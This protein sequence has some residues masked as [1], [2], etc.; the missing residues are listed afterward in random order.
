MID[1]ELSEDHKALV[2]TVREFAQNEVAPHIKEWDEK[3]QFN[4][5]VLKQMASLNLLGVCIPEEYGGFG[6]SAKVYNRIFGEL[7]SIDPALTVYFGAHQ[8]IGCKGIILFGNEEQKHRF[9]PKCAS[10]ESIAAFCLTE[11]GSGSDAQA[12]RSTAVPSADGSHYVLNG[13]KIWI[14]NAGYADVLTVFAKVPVEVDG[15]KKA[16]VTAFVVDA[17]AAGVSLGK[18]EYIGGLGGLRDA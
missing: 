6:A 3:Q 16:R 1:F 17:H 13:T 5:S 12:M 11:P 10:G 9:L 15:V 7:G 14:S 4:P 2:Q 18:L 8:S